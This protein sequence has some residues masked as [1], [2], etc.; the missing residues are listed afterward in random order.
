MEW[1]HQ[2]SS[3]KLLILMKEIF[4]EYTPLLIY[5]ELE[6]DCIDGARLVQDVIHLQK[7]QVNR[8]LT[9]IDQRLFENKI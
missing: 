2:L 7:M 8:Q 4:G 6:A 5:E 9:A 3:G 1:M